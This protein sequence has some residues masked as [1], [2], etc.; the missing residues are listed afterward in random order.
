MGRHY[1]EQSL[2]EVIRDM[3]KAGGL[4]RKYDQLEIE[5]CFREVVGEFISKRI[6]EVF[7]K[8]RKLILRSDSGPLKEEL[9]YSKSKIIGLVN[10]KMGSV[11]IEEL[12]IR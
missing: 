1:N 10:D 2:K 6:R 12:E 3:L 11:V 5:R 8:D 9:S 4:E 7:V